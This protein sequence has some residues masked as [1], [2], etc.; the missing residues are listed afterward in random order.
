MTAAERRRD[1]LLTV[2]FCLVVAAFAPLAWSLPAVV[3]GVAGT[4]LAEGL[5][6][7]R[8]T[9]VRRL[10]RRRAVRVAAFV[11]GLLS[12]ALLASVVGPAVWTA[13]LAG[14]VTYLLVLVVAEGRGR[15]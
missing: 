1:A 11:G 14:G 12:L 8:A 15:R 7:I 10:W 4:L 13:T 5:L 3:A 9:A 2:A 6:S